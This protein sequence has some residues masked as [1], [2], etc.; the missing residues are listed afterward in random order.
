MLNIDLM[1]GGEKVLTTSAF[2]LAVQR[3]KPS[4]FYIVDELDAALDRENSMRLAEMLSK[5]SAQFL[6]ITHN[7]ALMK[8]AQSV[9]G[10]SMNNGISQ[11]VGVKL[12]DNGKTSE[13]FRLKNI[14]M[15]AYSILTYGNENSILCSFV[16]FAFS[17]RCLCCRR[18]CAVQ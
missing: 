12:S 10:V 11:I 3:Y 16:F 13:N 7:E 1:S 5:T 8:Y 14:Y 15:P 18:R 4:H 2:L 9:I 17:K 6:L